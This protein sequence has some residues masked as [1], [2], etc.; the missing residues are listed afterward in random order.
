MRR[1]DSQEVDYLTEKEIEGCKR[2]LVIRLGRLGDTIMETPVIDLVRKS[3]GEGALIDFAASSNASS[4]IL[5]LDRRINQVYSITHRKLPST[6]HPVK[7]TLLHRSRQQPYDL[8]IN[9]EC[10]KACDDFH[11]FVRHREYLGLPLIEPRHVSSQ[12]SVNTE[13]SIY[14]D[15]L[16]PEMTEAAEPRLDIPPEPG[17]ETLFGGADY[18]VLN[19]SFFEILKKDYRANRGWPLEYCTELIDMIRQRTGLFVAVNGTVEDQHLF[20]PL[21]AG[22][23]VHSLLGCSLQQLTDALSGASCTISVDTG[24]M[25]LAAALGIPTI[26][27]FGPTLPE[28]T[29][30]YSKTAKHEVL[31]SGISCQPCHRTASE[32]SCTFA[33]CMRELSPESVFDS[34]TRHLI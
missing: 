25:H 13:K 11:E 8:V 28:L 31:Q 7:R 4:V 30:P 20:E 2:A 33:R 14:A 3:L 22:K 23:G 17:F 29:G 5:Q 12:H 15:R 18:V 21:P 24:T 16:G 32:K 26:A 27:L 6:I 9:L 10:G 19:P 34:M 1:K